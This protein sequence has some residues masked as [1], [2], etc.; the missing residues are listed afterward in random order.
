MFWRRTTGHGAFWGLVSGTLAAAAHYELTGVS[1]S[2]S[3][4]GKIALVHSYP[5]DMAQNFWGAIWAWT[6]CFLV[7]ILV[8][9]ATSPKRAE[10]L[11]GLVF[12]LTPKP[13][14][15]QLAWY[16][17]PVVLGVLVLICTGALNLIFW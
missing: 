4:F 8:S 17:R 6:I 14:D 9:L 15:D 12:G 2:A 1:N 5:S 3:L 13:A 7:T 10:D 16:Q 11:K